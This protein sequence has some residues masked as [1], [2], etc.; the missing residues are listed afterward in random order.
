LLNVAV[1]AKV[2]ASRA[3]QR[4]DLSIQSNCNVPSGI[5]TLPLSVCPL[6]F[7]NRSAAPAKEEAINQ[8]TDRF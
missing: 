2:A 8:Y 7:S 5:D 4:K 3:A 6:L 1:K